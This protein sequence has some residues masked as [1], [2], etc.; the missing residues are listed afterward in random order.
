MS[1]VIPQAVE[2]INSS[3]TTLSAAAFSFI[4]MQDP[5]F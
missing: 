1:Y 5:P 2:C 3:F 4:Q